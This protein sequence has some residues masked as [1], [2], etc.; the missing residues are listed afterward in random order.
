MKEGRV[1]ALAFGGEGIIKS[2]GKVVF[3]PFTAPGDLIQYRIVSDKARFQRGE[4]TK[5]IEPGPDRTE[6]QCPYFGK[7]GGC[8]LQHLNYSAQLRSKREAVSEALKRIGSVDNE[9]VEEVI[10]SK[11]WFYRRHISFNLQ[12]FEGFFKAGYIAIDQHSLLS[13]EECPIFCEKN[14]SILAHLHESVDA[15]KAHPGNHGRAHLFK[16]TEG[17]YLLVFHFKEKPENAETVLQAA[18]DKGVI[19]GILLKYHHGEEHLGNCQLNDHFFGMEVTYSPLGFLQNNAE[20]SGRIYSRIVELIA[21]GPILDLYC[22]IGLLSLL[23]SRKGLQV[24]GVENNPASIAIANQNAMKNGL[25]TT[26]IHGDV[27]ETVRT[28]LDTK[29]PSWVIVNPPREG[30][31]A[32]V[33][34]ALCQSAVKQILYVSCMPS[35]LARD[36]Q[37]FQRAGIQLISCEP[38]DMFPQTGHIE[39]LATFQRSIY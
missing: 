15:L 21:E 33:V 11:Q 13:V 12:P 5:L 22:G 7:C 34:Q 10:P 35:T 2:E 26:F 39:T 23:L 24:I 9:L 25:K 8:Q 3:V 18:L 32:P 27:A 6:P 14:D 31:A 4:M 28:L 37:L 30:L 38:F 1:K 29:K 36:T 19:R 17:G 20:Q 16:R